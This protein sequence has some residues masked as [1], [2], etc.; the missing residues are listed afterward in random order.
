MYM[1]NGLFPVLTTGIDQSETVRE[2]LFDMNKMFKAMMD[3]FNDWVDTKMLSVVITIVFAILLYIV[4]RKVIKWTLKFTKGALDR[5]SI[6]EGATGFICAM[7]KITLYFILFIML[8]GMLGI[9]TSSLVALIGSAGL[10]VG[11]ALKGTFSNFAGGLMI[12]FTKPFKV[13]DYIIAGT[14]EGEVTKIDI[15]YTHILTPDNKSI[16]F[17]NGDLSNMQL[18]NSTNEEIRRLDLIIPVGYETDIDEARAVLLAVCEKNELVI[19][20]EPMQVLLFEFGDSAINLSVR[21]W[22][23]TDDYWPLKWQLQEQIKKALDQAQISIPFNQLDV[24]IVN[25][26]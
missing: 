23:N 12:L 5:S 25:Q 11:L 19:K 18:T 14:F 21:V 22:T 16:V 24:N 15:V 10:S 26:N 3:S 13:G 9:N 2:R 8:A 4:G 6:E 20:T 17:P 7:V 1:N